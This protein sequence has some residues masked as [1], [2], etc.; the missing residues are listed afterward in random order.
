[1]KHA[2]PEEL[3]AGLLADYQKPD[4]LIGENGL[5]K[6]LTKMLVEQA[7]EAEMSEHLGHEQAAS[8][9]Q[10]DRQRPQWPER[11]DAERRFWRTAH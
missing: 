9:C 4:D 5:L 7:L 2:V 11:Q 6:R 8:R 1:M 10:R 3:L